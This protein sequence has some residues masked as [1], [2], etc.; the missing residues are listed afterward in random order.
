MNKIARLPKIKLLITS[1]VLLSI[2]FLSNAEEL[3]A[4]LE[5]L[6]PPPAHH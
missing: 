1:I 5:A 2:G 6:K 3:S 4:R